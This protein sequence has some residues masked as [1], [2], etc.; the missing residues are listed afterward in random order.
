MHLVARRA[1]L[2]QQLAGLVGEIDHQRAGFHQA[3]A[4]VGIDDR[5][6][7]V[8]RADLE[9]FRLELFVLADVDRMHRVGQADLLQH[10]GGLA[11]VRRGPGV[12]FD[13]R[14]FLVP[15]FLG[16]SNSSTA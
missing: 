5:G 16:K 15:S 10:D 2:R 4:G 8:V 9:K 7:A 14:S 11:A 6:D 1:V 13:H 3:D 12:E